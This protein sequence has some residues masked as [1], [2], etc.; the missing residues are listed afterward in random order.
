[1]PLEERRRPC[2]A[3]P[4]DWP[5]SAFP[6]PPRRGRP[7]SRSSRAG[8]RLRSRILPRRKKGDVTDAA[9]FF[10]VVAHSFLGLPCEGVPD[11]KPRCRLTNTVRHRCCF[12]NATGLHRGLLQGTSPILFGTNVASEMPRACT[13]DCYAPRYKTERPAILIFLHQ[14]GPQ[15]PLS[16]RGAM[17]ATFLHKLGACGEAGRIRADLFLA[18]AAVIHRPIGA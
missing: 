6:Q 16:S 10:C 4:D 7:P 13:V 3:A 12:G 11:L 2:Q 5:C 14:C 17:R 9:L 1:V 8:Q 18:S 15:P